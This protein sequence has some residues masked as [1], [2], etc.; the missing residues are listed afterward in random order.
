MKHF[1][2]ARL[3]ASIRKL[4]VLLIPWLSGWFL[5]SCFWFFSFFFHITTMQKNL[6]K[7][8]FQRFRLAKIT[9]IVHITQMPVT[10]LR[11]RVCFSARFRSAIS[12]RFLPC[13]FSFGKEQRKEPKEKRNK[14]VKLIIS[15]LYI[16]TQSIYILLVSIYKVPRIYTTYIYSEFILIG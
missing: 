3:N 11:S 10:W 6:T 7:Q 16:Y 2:F 5:I 15:S 9:R 1:C 8:S 12:A 4:Y 14:S 13:K